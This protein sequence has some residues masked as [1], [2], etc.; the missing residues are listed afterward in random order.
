MQ[1]ASNG[2]PVGRLSLG[3]A[4]SVEKPAQSWFLAVSMN[5]ICVCSPLSCFILF[6]RI[7]SV[8]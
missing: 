5:I 6:L 3:D 4:G 7:I 8:L 1:C 2:V